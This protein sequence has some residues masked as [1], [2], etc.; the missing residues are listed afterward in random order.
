M[1]RERSTSAAVAAL[2][3]FQTGQV[4]AQVTG[5]GAVETF[6][7]DAPVDL[8]W[9]RADGEECR[10][11]PFGGE[12]TLTQGIPCESG[13]PQPITLRTKVVKVFVPAGT[14]VNVW[15]YRY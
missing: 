14:R 1:P 7:F 2:D 15:G 4:L 10:T 11:D 3:Y 13:V 9:V 5:Q 8:L 6:T 12:P